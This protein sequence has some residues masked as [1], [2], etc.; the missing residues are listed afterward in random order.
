MTIR[1]LLLTVILLATAL[2]AQARTI[3]D[4]HD[5]M[6]EV[7]TPVRRMVLGDASLILSLALLTR[8]PA[9]P[10]AGWAAEGRLDPDLRRALEARFPATGQIA[11][12]GGRDLSLSIESVIGIDPDVLV[13]SGMEPDA[14]PLDL[15]ERLAI[16]VIFLDLPAED[17]QGILSETWRSL[18]ILGQLL[19]EEERAAD[20]IAFHRDHANRLTERLRDIPS[21]RPSVLFHAHADADEPCCMSPGARSDYIEFSGGENIGRSLL[22]VAIGQISLEHVL[23]ANPGVYVATGGKYAAGGIRLGPGADPQ[24]AQNDLEKLLETSPLGQL[25]A[26]RTGRAHGL[27]HGL[28][29]TPL[30]VLALE[31]MAKWFQPEL[32]KDVDPAETLG[33]INKRF[34]A[35]PI[36][37]ALWVDQGAR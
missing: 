10:V 4:A 33:Q 17:T 21:P 15:F 12:L 8:N 24:T 3:R 35:L 2:P 26:P 34:L 36:D 5:R 37:G 18:E 32:F 28:L 20:F 1:R 13:V 23:A 31:A 22:P 7:A 19:G 14:L 25:D 27:W 16:P 30:N 29:A 6:V 11:S 9:A